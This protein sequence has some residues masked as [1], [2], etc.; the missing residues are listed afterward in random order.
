MTTFFYRAVCNG[1]FMDI[2]FYRYMM[3]QADSY[4][5]QRLLDT[6]RFHRAYTLPDPRITYYVQEYMYHLRF[7]TQIAIADF[8]ALEDALTTALRASWIGW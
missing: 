7:N 1:M 6:R 3:I 2:K 4:I 8:P 5:N